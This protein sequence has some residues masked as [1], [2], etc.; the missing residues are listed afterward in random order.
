MNNKY[1]TMINLVTSCKA[2]IQLG[3]YPTT[4]GW[5]TLEFLP[6]ATRQGATSFEMKN[7]N[8]LARVRIT[9]G[10]ITHEF[11]MVMNDIRSKSKK[12]QVDPFTEKDGVV[13]FNDNLLIS[14]SAK[15]VIDFKDK[16]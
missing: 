13:K 9:D 4:N 12:A 15:G 1:T 6:M 3:E 7:G 16:K 11:G 8:E 5:S 10:D 2:S 14:I